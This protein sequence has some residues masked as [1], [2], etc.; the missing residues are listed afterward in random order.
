MSADKLR[1][2]TY[3]KEGKMPGGLKRLTMSGIQV[4]IWMESYPIS[5]HV[6]LAIESMYSADEEMRK[7]N[8]RRKRIRSAY[9][10][11]TT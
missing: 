2:Q 8:V 4:A 11:Q 10:I 7:K 5:A 9:T 3:I 6:T 1:E